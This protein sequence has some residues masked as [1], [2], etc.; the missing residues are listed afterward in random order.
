MYSNNNNKQHNFIVPIITY[1][2]NICTDEVRKITVILGHL[3]QLCSIPDTQ[4]TSEKNGLTGSSAS[5]MLR[6][7]QQLHRSLLVVLIRI[8]G[9]GLFSN[10]IYH[11][12]PFH[13]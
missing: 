8:L 3:I 6:N 9:N 5:V 11:F 12:S 7:H 13:L 1:T 10:V 2:K 4:R